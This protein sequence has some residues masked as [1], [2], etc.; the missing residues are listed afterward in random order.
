V[1]TAGEGAGTRPSRREALVRG[2]AAVAALAAG[3][4]VDGV[5]RVLAAGDDAALLTTLA[6]L[7]DTAVY[8]YTTLAPRLVRAPLPGFGQPFLLHHRRHRDLLLS[9]LHGLHAPP[10]P[11]GQAHPDAVPATPGEAAAIAALLAVEER[12]LGAQYAA[13]AALGSQPLRVQVASVFGVD[14]RHATV[15]RSASGQD[16]VPESF[17]TGP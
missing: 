6:L 3:P 15:W 10:P 7:E 4:F 12:L 1:S 16:P 5:E 13:L 8:V 14:A 17:V 11:T 2:G 9:A